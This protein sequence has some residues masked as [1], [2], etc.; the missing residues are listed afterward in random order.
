MT[1]RP[2]EFGVVAMSTCRL[3]NSFFRD[4][5]AHKSSKKEE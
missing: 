3:R 4:L 5:R 2:F 1:D